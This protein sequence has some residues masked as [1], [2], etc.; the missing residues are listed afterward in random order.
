MLEMISNSNN[1][2]RLHTFVKFTKNTPTDI[3]LVLMVGLFDSS[4]A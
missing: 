4:V 2:Y 1:A 3:Y